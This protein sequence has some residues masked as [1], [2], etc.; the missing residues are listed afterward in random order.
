M[1]QGR[2]AR[3]AP[4][5]AELQKELWEPLDLECPTLV[6][7]TTGERDP[8][9]SEIAGYVNGLYARPLVHE[10]DLD[11]PRAEAEAGP[12]SGVSGSEG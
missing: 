8:S 10:L 7:D 3:L 6:V 12:Y 1:G 4:V 9:V 5:V 11:Q 2:R